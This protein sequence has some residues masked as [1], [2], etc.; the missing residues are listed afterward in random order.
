[1]MP[2]KP[3]K[4]TAATVSSGDEAYQYLVFSRIAC[5]A[6]GAALIVYG[7]R[8]P[9][10]ERITT[11]ATP[12]WNSFMAGLSPIAVGLVFLGLQSQF[13]RRP[14]AL[15]AVT[16]LSL[17]LLFVSVATAVT[18][19]VKQVALFPLIFAPAAALGT[20]LTQARLARTTPNL[21]QPQPVRKQIF[22]PGAYRKRPDDD[23]PIDVEIDGKLDGT[24]AAPAGVLAGSDPAAPGS[25]D[26]CR[27]H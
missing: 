21:S 27:N 3:A 10:I 26:A 4:S 1:M 14:W 5:I 8:I 23:A 24:V 13:V 19:G 18:E 12:S 2:Q 22:A 15:G 16:L 11:G 20:W 6:L 25:A 17:V 7:L 9:I